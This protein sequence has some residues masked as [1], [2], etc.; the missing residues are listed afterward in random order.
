[1][2]LT[3]TCPIFITWLV[4]L[5]FRIHGD[6][7]EYRIDNKVVRVAQYIAK[8]ESLGIAIKAK[9]FLVFQVCYFLLNI[10]CHQT[11]YNFVQL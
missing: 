7:T 6:Q 8:L 1:M 4:L 9:N 3:K 5:F 11:G 2:R 10:C